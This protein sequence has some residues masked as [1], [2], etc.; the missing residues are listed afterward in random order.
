MPGSGLRRHPRRHPRPHPAGLAGE[1]S[2]PPARTV[3]AE[4]VVALSDAVQVDGDGRAPGRR[5]EHQ[6][7]VSV[8]K[9]IHRTRP[10]TTS[11]G[12]ARVG[13]WDATG[14]TRMTKSRPRV[15]TYRTI[16]ALTAARPE[17]ARRSGCGRRAAGAGLDPGRGQR[18]VHGNG[19][20]AEK[21]LGVVDPGPDAQLELQRTVAEAGAQ[22][23]G[24]WIRER[25]GMRRGDA[26]ED[27]EDVLRVGRVR[28]ANAERDAA[29]RLRQR[30]V[31]DALGCQGRVRDDDLGA[32]P[33]PDGGRPHADLTDP[34][35]ERAH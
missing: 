27:L 18:A 4:R 35:L 26:A 29:Q 28:D 14:D 1:R 12:S 3:P 17:R 23:D 9:S 33:R 13:G 5:D 19:E 2:P 8:P 21:R 16:W 32:V 6:R 11:G 7:H 15:V 25:P 30:P 22:T 31:G 24:R 34:A 20:L 10:S